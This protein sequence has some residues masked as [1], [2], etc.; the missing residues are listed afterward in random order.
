MNVHLENPAGLWWLLLLLIV[1]TLYLLRR[2]PVSRRV[3]TLAFFKALAQEHRE[4]QWL[5]R[6]KRLIALVISVLLVAV[7]VLVLAHPIAAPETGGL[8]AVVM[9]FDTSASM[10]A[11]DPAPIDRARADARTRLAGLDPGVEVMVIAHDRRARVLVPRTLDRPSVA[12]AIDE[13]R[14]RPV[15]GRP[16]DPAALTAASASAKN[17]TRQRDTEVWHYTDHRPKSS[18]RA[19]DRLVIHERIFRPTGTTNAGI[20][21]F[22][23]R[24]KPLSSGEVEAFLRVEAIT[25][26]PL[27]VELSVHLDGELVALRT[28][29]IEPGVPES[30]VLPVIAGKDSV[31]SITLEA[32]QDLLAAD[33]LVSAPVGDLSP[34]RVLWVREEAD[35]FLQ[36]ALQAIAE[37]GQAQVFEATPDRWPPSPSIDVVIL[38]GWLPPTWPTERPT[39]VIEPP[40]ALGPVLAV[41]LEGGGRRW[42]LVIE[43]IRAAS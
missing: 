28:I 2:R 27:P 32:E 17:G 19:T 20:T 31:L 3:S 21:A 13:L 35:P 11:G 25:Q 15:A 34:P 22:A 10:G 36:L 4:A 33:N 6:L 38:D 14:A 24:S 23:L 40:R 5:R 1:A 8:A 7:T 37:T 18:N 41:P 29:V 9:L 39:L 43:R 26:E 16:I 42:M 30:L 12:A